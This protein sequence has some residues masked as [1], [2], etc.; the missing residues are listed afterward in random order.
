M[1]PRA[2]KLFVISAIATAIF[3]FGSTAMAQSQAGLDRSGARVVRAEPGR[4]LTA[5]SKAAPADVVTGFLR[6]RGRSAAVLA[7]LRTTRSSGG[8][9][10]VTHVRMEQV[11]EGLTVHGAYLKA[12]VNARGETV[13]VIDRLVNVSSPA[14]A[15]VDAAQALR[16]AMARVHPSESIVFA[17]AG[18]QGNTATFN[19]GS[20][21]HSPPAVTAVAVPMSNG[22]LARGWLVETWTEKGNQ[23][24]HTLVGGD[25][26]VLDVERRTASDRYN[27]FLEDPGKGPQTVVT[28]PAVGN[29]LSPAGWLGSGTQKTTNIT[30]NNANAY[31][32]VDSNNRADRGGTSVA[33]GDFLTAADLTAQPSTAGNAAVAVQN[34]FYLNNVIHDILYSRGFD[35]AAGNF[36]V[37]NF[38]KGGAGSDPVL[39]E[40][41][42]GGG[43]DN[44]N[45]ATPTDGKK[46]RMQMYLWNGPGPTHE[47]KVN[48]PTQ[49]SFA[50]KG[51]EFGP[52]MTVTGITGSVSTTSPADGCTAIS[53]PLSGKVA[54][55]DRG[56]CAFTVKALNAQAAGATAMVI[57]NNTGGTETFLM[58]GTERKVRIPSVMISQ[59][60][61]ASVK[62]IASPNATVHKLAVQPLQLDGSVDADI[63]FH[64]Y[65]HGLSWRMIG[66]MSGPLAGAIGEGNSD[67]IAMLVNGDD[68]MGEYSSSNPLGIRRYRY[69][70]YPLTYANVTGAEVHDDGE[71]YA[72]IVWKMMSLFGES[73]RNDLF[74]YVVDGM[75]Y[76]P[77]TPTY[78]QMRDGILGSVSNGATPTDCSMVW[79]A[80]A[81][82]GVGVGA[83]GV[84]N[85]SAV[86]ITPSFTAPSSC[87]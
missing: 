2:R 9:N 1:N 64:E 28:G 56:T 41:Q 57:A 45:F 30:G 49:V 12:A 20:F 61:G 32:D 59:N 6:E 66:G 63:V 52:A 11:V 31:L 33:N 18:S 35:E 69:E 55:I 27:V 29:A 80:F 67:G 3:S 53:T 46:P 38:S 54:L 13:N 71:I 4:P 83:Q 75:N 62:A 44:A 76:T 17:P 42:D 79:Q 26:T 77:A 74:R 5:A 40:A 7:S 39:A 43:T 81:Q 86:T 70:N 85:G 58:G 19:G 8:A 65:G 34:L 82:Y 84:V 10:G 16:A 22:T 21:F 47:V 68:V 15:K 14:P 37:D 50:A 73:R 23:L 87:N 24:D 60:D 51:A 48:S 72:A 78:E 36:Q 25:G